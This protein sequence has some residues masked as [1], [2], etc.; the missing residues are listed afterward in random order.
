MDLQ[1]DFK[2]NVNLLER[3]NLEIEDEYFLDISF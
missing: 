3:G 2:P 1:K